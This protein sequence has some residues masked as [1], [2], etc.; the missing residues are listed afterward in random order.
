MKLNYKLVAQTLSAVPPQLVKSLLHLASW[1]PPEEIDAEKVVLLWVT[2]LLLVNRVVSTAGV[3]FIV[4]TLGAA[5]EAEGAKF[6]VDISEGQ[7]NSLVAHLTIGDRRIV[8]MSGLSD[9]LDLGTGLTITTLYVPPLEVI[10][11]NLRRLF[12]TY[13]RRYTRAVEDAR[14]KGNPD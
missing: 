2:D 9:V 4:A 8:S 11:Y 12:V 10:T 13:Y 5:L 7:F 3:E 1:P 14:V 6:F